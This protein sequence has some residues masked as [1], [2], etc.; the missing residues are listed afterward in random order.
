MPS[1]VVQISKNELTKIIS[2]VIEQKLFELFGDPDEG[3]SM[4]QSL[5][6]RL[7]RQKR[8]VGNGERGADLTSIRKRLDL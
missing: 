2:N 3:L 6:K 7:L 5:R 4:K 1:T 8:S